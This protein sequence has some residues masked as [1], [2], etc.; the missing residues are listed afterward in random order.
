MSRQFATN[1]TTIYDIFCPVPFLPSPFGFPPGLKTVNRSC[2]CTGCHIHKSCNGHVVDRV[3]K[4]KQQPNRQKCPKNVQNVLRGRFR[5]FVGIFRHFSGYCFDIWSWFSFAG[6][7]NDL[8]LQH[9]S[10]VPS[11]SRSESKT[12]MFLACMVSLSQCCARLK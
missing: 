4:H 10:P 2:P 6:P 12:Q 3:A 9:K 11:D 8:L 5:T 1:V 7:S